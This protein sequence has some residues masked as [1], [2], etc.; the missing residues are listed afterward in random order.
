VLT[1]GDVLP[2]MKLGKREALK[3]QD[4]GQFNPRCLF[5]KPEI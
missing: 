5:T 3:P 4:I 2:N 1:A